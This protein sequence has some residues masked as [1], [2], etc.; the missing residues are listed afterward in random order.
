N[1]RTSLTQV[2]AE[3]L[4]VPMESIKMVMGDTDLTPYDAGTFGSQTTPSMVP[5]LRK[6]AAT[7]REGLIDLAAELFHTDRQQLVAA[8]GKVTWAAQSKSVTFG[9]LTK[10]QEI[11][12]SISDNPPVAPPDG[13]KITGTSAPKVNGEAHVTGR[14]KYASDMTAP[15]M[16]YG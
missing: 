7:A 6:V 3:E 15:E 11:T 12:R 14:H 13:W 1:A 16:L 5:Q 8:H 2:V 10:G 9:E 4:P